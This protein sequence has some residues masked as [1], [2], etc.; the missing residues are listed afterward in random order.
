VITPPPDISAV[1]PEVFEAV[2]TTLRR[3]GVGL[4]AAEDAT[5]EAGSRVLAH[6][7]GFTDADDLRRWVQTV[8][9]RL[10]IDESRRLAR[11]DG[12]APLEAASFQEVPAEVEHR[13]HL[14]ATR[15]AWR[16]LSPA[17]REAIVGSGGGDHDRCPALTRKEAVRLAVRRHR[18]RA[19]LLAL[20]EGV[21]A[22][23]LVGVR[24]ARRL[25]TAVMIAAIVPISVL[26]LPFVHG[27]GPASPTGQGGGG[28]GADG[29]GGRLTGIALVDTVSPA[30]PGL[31]TTGTADVGG[32]DAGVGRGGD[33]A[34]PHPKAPAPL[35]HIDER[36][37]TPMADDQD[38]F[39][40]SRPKDPGQPV[41]CVTVA[42]AQACAPTVGA[43]VPSPTQLVP[44][45]GSS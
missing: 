8:A 39:L 12:D 28:A 42:V 20:V 13:L 10:A 11:Y 4:H 29:V 1:W 40:R 17:D 21:A 27:D 23:V 44:D 9:W 18:A 34:A 24:R 5:Q 16:T 15:K 38:P 25:S 14:A 19:R 37:D 36:V 30:S 41:A 22:I 31:V 2:V 32:T 33:G 6:E 7:I 35:Q 45:V 3:R 43:D 26:V